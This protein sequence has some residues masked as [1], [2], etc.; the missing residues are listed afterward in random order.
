MYTIPFWG[1]LS[2]L[3]QTPSTKK[4][5]KLIIGPNSPR[6]PVAW[7]LARSVLQDEMMNDDDYDYDYFI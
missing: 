1:S 6:H 7:F 4:K 2:P 5:K 3:S